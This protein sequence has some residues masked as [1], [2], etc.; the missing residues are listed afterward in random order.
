MTFSLF[1]LLLTFFV[2][3]IAQ[4]KNLPD[5]ATDNTQLSKLRAILP[6]VEI[7]DESQQRQFQN[8]YSSCHE[9][10]LITNS[11]IQSTKTY[12]DA[13]KITHYISQYL[14]IKINEVK[15]NLATFEQ[16]DFAYHK[17]GKSIT[18]P[19]E[20]MVISLL[21]KNGKWLH[22][23]VHEHEWH[24]TELHNWFFWLILAFV[25]ISAV[26]IKLISYLTK[27][28]AELN[29]AAQIFAKGLEFS[30]VKESG[31]PDLRQLI[32]SFNIM[33]KDVLKAL[34][35]RTT[36]IAAISHDI[37][38]PLTSLRLKAELLD[39]KVTRSSFVESI[40]KI[41]RITASA[42][43][44]L[45]GDNKE[46]TKKLINFAAMLKNECLD[47]SEI[48]HQVSYIGT[49]DINVNCR[50]VALSRA[51]RNLIENAIKYGGNCQV[52]LTLSEKHIV[53]KVSDSGAGIHEDDLVKALE[54]F[55]RLSKARESSQGGFGLG[56]AIVKTIVEGHSGEFWLENLNPHG[57]IAII[58][59]P[60]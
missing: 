48:G 28:L 1:L 47:F 7:L 34:K 20:G 32:K 46:E 4:Q 60:Y 19:I 59:L 41:E 16:S 53:I 58:R 15:V 22:A 45:K 10:Y 54:P 6:I 5:T 17:C 40:N 50:P 18:F 29:N 26:S 35:N 36:T 14:S 51:I 27:P 42:L 55:H 11:P 49:V 33:Q 52:N 24:L 21:L 31:S 39:D 30:E 25:I 57:L 44:F 37:R 38:T 13:N 9:G 43:D 8:R 3:D 2:V 23:E 56:L 12:N